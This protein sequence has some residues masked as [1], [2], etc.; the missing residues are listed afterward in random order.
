MK[1]LLKAMRKEIEL[2]EADQAVVSGYE[3]QEKSSEGQRSYGK[4]GHVN[5]ATALLARQQK[6]R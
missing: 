4:K 1:D 5:S 6:P 2:R 3:V